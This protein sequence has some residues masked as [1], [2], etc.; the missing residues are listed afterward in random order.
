[1][2]VR[3]EHHASLLDELDQMPVGKQKTNK[4]GDCRV[5]GDPTR[6]AIIMST[7][8]MAITII[9]MRTLAPALLLSVLGIDTGEIILYVLLYVH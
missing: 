9:T 3:H 8:M 6:S 7:A 2:V 4:P 1:M 5:H